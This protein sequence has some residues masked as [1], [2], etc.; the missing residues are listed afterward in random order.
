MKDENPNGAKLSL[1]I[2]HLMCEQAMLYDTDPS[3]GQ[4]TPT[5]YDPMVDKD[6]PELKARM[7]QVYEYGCK[8]LISGMLTEGDLKEAVLTRLAGRVGMDGKE[9]DEHLQM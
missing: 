4:M 9:L 3:S 2:Y 5:V 8:M 7:K 6:V 1:L